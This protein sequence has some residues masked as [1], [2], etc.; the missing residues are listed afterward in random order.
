MIIV[1]LSSLAL[2]PS[3]TS[4]WD[5]LDFSLQIFYLI[6]SVALFVVL[7]QAF[8]QLLGFGVDDI[9]DYSIDAGE[10]GSG[11]KILSVRS[12]AAFFFGFGWTGVIVLKSGGS[13]FAAIGAGAV[14]GSIAMLALYFLL[15]SLSRL[16][17]SGTLNLQN[18]IGK[19][20]KVYVT[21]PP[22]M[23]AG[24][25]VEVNIQSRVICLDARTRKGESLRTGSVV[26]VVELLGQNTL[27]VE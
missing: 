7:L 22:E 13:I 15:S 25:Q 2:I 8:L 4:W 24:G 9:A 26:R 12:L 14:V 21:I 20:G 6:G 11:L 27:I 10:H 23:A 3:I 17:D 18:A 1:S 5:N 19:E 16:K